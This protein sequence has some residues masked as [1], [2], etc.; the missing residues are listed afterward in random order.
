MGKGPG[1]KN[2]LVERPDGSRFVTTYA[3][4]KHKYSKEKIVADKDFK[5]LGGFV[6][7]DVDTREVGNQEVRDVTIRQIGE[8]GALIRITVWPEHDADEVPIQRGDLI[9]VD[10]PFEQRVVDTDSGQKVY[11]NASATSLVVIP[12]A[13]KAEKKVANQKPKRAAA[14]SK[15]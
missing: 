11:L 7:F 5:G 12:P 1:P 15:F 13:P 9:F 6:Q 4:W 8:A 10:G 3:L 2:V 14:K